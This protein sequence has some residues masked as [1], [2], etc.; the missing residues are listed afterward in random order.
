MNDLDTD[1][2]WWAL[3]IE[4][5]LGFET[6]ESRFP[7]RREHAIKKATRITDPKLKDALLYANKDFE[8]IKVEK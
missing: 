8:A 2:D 1:G 3:I 5:A 4:A 7:G 6:W